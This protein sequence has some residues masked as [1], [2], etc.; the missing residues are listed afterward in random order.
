MIGVK[1]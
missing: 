1:S